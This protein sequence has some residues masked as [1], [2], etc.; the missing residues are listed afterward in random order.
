M[1]W[2]QR[3]CSVAIALGAAALVACVSGPTIL[4]EDGR[5]ADPSAPTMRAGYNRYRPMSQR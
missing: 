3:R 1:T 5:S 4:S 2:N